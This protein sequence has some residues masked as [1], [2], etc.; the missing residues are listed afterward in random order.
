[1]A[2]GKLPSVLVVGGGELGS[3]TAHRLAR[4]GMEV[5]MVDIA[6]PRCIR[7]KV[8]FAMALLDGE[9]RV[10]GV[11][12]RKAS[13]TGE[14]RGIAERGEIPVMAMDFRKILPDMEPDVLVDARM[15]KRESDMS[16]DLAP[17]VVGLGPGFRAGIDADVVVETQRGH[18]LGRVICEGSAE[19]HTGVPGEI[20]GFRTERV[21][22]APGSGSF[23]S[24]IGLGALVDRGAVLGQIDGK[25]AVVAP[26]A[27]L[28]RGLVADDTEV[29]SG[30]KMGDIDP[31]GSSIDPATISDKGRA[32]AGGVLEAIMHWWMGKAHD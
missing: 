13:T 30:Q 14:A 7:R 21:V 10:E 4:S 22:R 16:R 29:E 27:G 5:S 8:C 6:R 19:P 26:I 20:M 15:L 25:V 31:R 32:V 17:F 24:R 28:V 18:D 23:R 12:A 11:T 1:V 2:T 3:A 9:C